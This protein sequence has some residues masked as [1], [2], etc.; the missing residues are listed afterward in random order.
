[1]NANKKLKKLIYNNLNGIYKTAKNIA[2]DWDAKAIPLNTLRVIIDK[3]KPSLINNPEADIFIK[4]Y[5]ATLES[6]FTG[7][8]KITSKMNTNKIPLTELEKGILIIKRAF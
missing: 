5:N 1:M 6:L 2:N 7:C 3:S 8:E 4:Q